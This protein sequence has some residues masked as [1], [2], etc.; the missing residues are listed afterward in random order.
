MAKFNVYEPAVQ[1]AIIEAAARLSAVRKGSAEE[2]AAF[3]IELLALLAK[4]PE[5][6]AYATL[7]PSP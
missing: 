4:K 3:A 1:A 2:T 7:P 6:A 5:E